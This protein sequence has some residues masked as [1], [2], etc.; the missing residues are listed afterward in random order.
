[1][2][3]TY[4]LLLNLFCILGFSQSRVVTEYTELNG[5]LLDSVSQQPI[6]S[7][8]IWT[9]HFKTSS[10]ANGSFFLLIQPEDSIHISHVSYNSKIVAL[11]TLRNSALVKILMTQ[12]IIV[13]DAVDIHRVVSEDD[14]KKKI[15]ETPITKSEE[16]QNAE[17]NMAAL[18]YYIRSIPQV[19]MNANENYREYMKGPQG[20]T[21]FSS[22][23]QRGLIKA[24]RDVIKSKPVPYKSFAKQ[25]PHVIN[26]NSIS[27]KDSLHK[28]DQQKT[29]SL[30]LQRIKK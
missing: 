1:M 12:R 20:V 9:K 14:F 4:A 15:I 19:G 6:P 22:N 18:N 27:R 24:I 13:L 10:N 28:Q 5:V 25:K 11:Q 3:V 23:G 17:A 2:R 26:F 29:D 16:E 7:A 21:I 8:H 30:K